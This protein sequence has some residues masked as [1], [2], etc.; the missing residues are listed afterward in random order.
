MKKKVINMIKV[1]F[2]ILFCVM[3][4]SCTSKTIYINDE[5]KFFEITKEDRFVDKNIKEDLKFFHEVQ[6]KLYEV[7]ERGYETTSY[8][9]CLSQKYLDIATE[10]YNNNDRSDYVEKSLEKSLSILTQMEVFLD[11]I[12]Y[13]ENIKT[14]YA[15]RNDYWNFVEEIKS[16]YEKE[17]L[18]D[19]IDCGQCKL[20]ELETELLNAEHLNSELG[21]RN[22]L[23]S[24]RSAEKI[25]KELKKEINYCKDGGGYNL[26]ER[27]LYFKI[28]KD[29]LRDVSIK[30][31]NVVYKILNKNKSFKLKIN[32]YTD[33]V[34]TDEYNN[35]LSKRRAM[36]AYNFLIKKGIDKK[37]LTVNYFGEKKQIKNYL[38]K[39]SYA[40][41]RRVDLV[42]IE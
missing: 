11:D 23:R 24:I 13:P 37:R 14:D 5:K 3:I 41:N 27:R 20:A 22:S 4:S 2:L 29:E 38:N 1:K 19:S 32:G 34:G 28:N 33:P 8:P 15:V 25:Y 26:I 40:I 31:L 21:L 7:T 16:F 9:Y 30:K 17:Q 36:S 18:L 39:K 6:S 10:Q 12:I 42:I 35:S